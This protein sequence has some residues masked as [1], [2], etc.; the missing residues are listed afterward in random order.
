MIYTLYATNIMHKVYKSTARKPIS[1][2]CRCR[3]WYYEEQELLFSAYLWKI[4]LQRMQKTAEEYIILHNFA[5]NYHL[6]W[7]RL[8]FAVFAVSLDI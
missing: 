6:I 8:S 1:L 4:S 2:P 3:K 7:M 5:P